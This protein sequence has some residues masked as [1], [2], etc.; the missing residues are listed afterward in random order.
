MAREAVGKITRVSQA[1]TRFISVPAR[2]VD[3]GAFPFELNEKVL[4]VLDEE[5]QQLIVKKLPLLEE[6]S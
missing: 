2:V 3:D 4:I 6:E 1:R 5:N